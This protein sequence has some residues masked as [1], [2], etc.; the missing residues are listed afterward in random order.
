MQ[1]MLHNLTHKNGHAATLNSIFH[2]KANKNNLTIGPFSF[3]FLR[4]SLKKHE[5]GHS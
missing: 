4:F 1:Q 2:R 5:T 3:I